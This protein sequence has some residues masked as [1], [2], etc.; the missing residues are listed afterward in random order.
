MVPGIGYAFKCFKGTLG[1]I[2]E[3]KSPCG[4][5]GL[6]GRMVKLP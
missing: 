4:C 5:R 1:V 3:L 2:E 6:V